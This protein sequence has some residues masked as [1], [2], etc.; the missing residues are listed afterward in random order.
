LDR[1]LPASDARADAAT[2]K[3][4]DVHVRAAEDRLKLALGTRVRIVRKGKGGRIEIDFGNENELIRIF[5]AL[6]DK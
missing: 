1:T 5:E 2:A 6:T 3:V 4:G